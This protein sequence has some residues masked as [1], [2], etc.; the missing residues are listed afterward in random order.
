VPSDR[1]NPGGDA[2]K[3][4]ALYAP[5]AGGIEDLLR[6]TCADLQLPR[7]KYDAAN[8]HYQTI[9]DLVGRAPSPIAVHMPSMYPQ[10][11]MPLL[12]TVRPVR[13][14]EFDLDFV[15]EMTWSGVVP[16]SPLETLASFLDSNGNY[17]GKVKLRPRCVRLNYAGDFH[18]DIIPALPD[19]ARGVGAILVPDRDAQ[20]W[21]PSNPKGYIAWFE[22]R[23]RMRRAMLK[24]EDVQ[25][26]PPQRS[27]DDLEPLK[28]VV[29][30]MKRNRDL[31]FAED[32]TAGPKSILISTLAASAYDGSDNVQEAFAVVLDGIDRATRYA[33]RVPEIV[34]P[35]N[36]DE[37]LSRDW[38]TDA[39]AF[40]RFRSWFEN[41]QK[42]WSLLGRSGSF[43]D[44]KNIL[45]GLF[46][47]ELVESV[48]A[49]QAQDVRTAA[50]SGKLGMTEST[51]RLTAAAV[52][53]GIAKVQP[54]RFFGSD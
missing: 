14:I 28:L 46:G 16:R 3:L 4:E 53:S 30:L 12:T 25:S 43:I 8:L 49:S 17:K 37:V 18:L 40:N 35:T 50:Q 24:A 7:H 36:P 48:Y 33:Y 41:V 6:R 13:G 10:G 42:Q 2:V 34:N 19:A 39:G 23:A 22:G 5:P 32:L 1:P 27:V 38:L 15:A 45:D 44:K 20:Q 52:V 54:H 31:V 29:Q 21:I 26:L 11:S 9:A 47:K 51:T